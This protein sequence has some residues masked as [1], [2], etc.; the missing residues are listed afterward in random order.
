MTFYSRILSA[1]ELASKHER[2]FSLPAKERIKAFRTLSWEVLNSFKSTKEH[3]MEDLDL[4]LKILQSTIRT[5]VSPSK[6][7][8][9]IAKIQSQKLALLGIDE[10]TVLKKKK[11]TIELKTATIGVVDA[12]MLALPRDYETALDQMR[13]GK[14][15]L[16]STASDGIENIEIRLTDSPV[17]LLSNKETKRIIGGS[18]QNY[19]LDSPTGRL[20]VYDYLSDHRDS[21][22]ELQVDP[23]YYMISV[24][25]FDFPRSYQ[26]SYYIALSKALELPENQSNEIETLEP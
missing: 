12:S 11:G 19:V 9:G 13:M 3:S 5:D 1:K 14:A 4:Y 21:F 10:P 26:Y 15:F 6:Y 8:N 24:F 7:A 2:L 17:P 25:I 22:V 16:F 20:L 18:S 23:G